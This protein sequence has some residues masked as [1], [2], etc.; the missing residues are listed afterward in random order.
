MVTTIPPI[1]QSPD[2]LMN[3]PIGQLVFMLD[4][5][6]R[7]VM[8]W[9]DLIQAE[10]NTMQRQAILACLEREETL[11]RVAAIALRTRAVE[12]SSFA[13]R[14]GI[15]CSPEFLR[16]ETHLAACAFVKHMMKQEYGKD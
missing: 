5:R 7:R 12:A 4:R 14:L 6:I 16:E 9:I 11:V 2:D 8:D 10:S 13:A 1:L 3:V 15:R